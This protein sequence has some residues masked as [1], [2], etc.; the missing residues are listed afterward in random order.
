IAAGHR[1][2]TRPHG[3][4]DTCRL[5]A[6]RDRDIGTVLPGA[7][8]HV[9]EVHAGRG[10]I[11]AHLAGPRLRGRGLFDDHLPGPARLTNHDALHSASD[12]RCVYQPSTLAKMRGATMVASDSMMNDGVSTP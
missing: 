5:A 9:D 12:G 4:N 7:E 8:V 10:D 1:R 11:D 2:H 6:D 3:R